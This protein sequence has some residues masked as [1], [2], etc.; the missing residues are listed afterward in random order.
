MTTLTDPVFSQRQVIT[1]E[2]MGA[3]A[4]VAADLDGDGDMDVVSASSTDNTVAWYERL[5]DGSFSGKKQITFSSNGARI[6]TTGDIDAD[7]FVDIV[8]ASYY[9][10]TVGW[11]KNSGTGTF[12]NLEGVEQTIIPIT[13]TADDAQGVI[14]A[15]IDGDGDL[16]VVSASSGDHTIAWYMNLGRDGLFCEVKNV[17]DS[18]AQ[19]ARTVVAADIDGDGDVDLASAAKDHNTIAWYPN[20]GHGNFPIKHVVYDQA[21]GAYS[22]VAKDVDR[23]GKVDLVTA[24]NA[25]DTIAFFRNLGSTPTSN[26]T[27]QRIEIFTGADFVLSVFAADLDGD[28]DIDAASAGF[29]DHTIRWHENLD[30]TGDSWTTHDIYTGQNSGGHYIFGEDM[31]N[32]G[33]TD[34]IAVMNGANEVMLL[35]ASTV[36]DTS[37]APTCCRLNQQWNG[38]SCVDCGPSLYGDPNPNLA[39][40]SCIACPTDCP[41]PASQPH[42]PVSC[43]NVPTCSTP[44]QAI[45]MCDCA[46]DTYKD[47]ETDVCV[48]CPEGFIRTPSRTRTMNDYFTSWEGFNA[49]NCVLYVP[50]IPDCGAGRFFNTSNEQ[51]VLC[52]DGTFSVGGAIVE[53]SECEA[54]FAC[55]AGENHPCQAG[56]FSGPGASICS[57]APR[58]THV[59]SVLA[60]EPT[61]CP[62]GFFANREGMQDC[63]QC[64]LGS[65]SGS[66]VGGISNSSNISVGAE[67]CIECPIS[68]TTARL[69]SRDVFDC[70]C[71]SGTFHE[72]HGASCNLSVDSPIEEGFC[73]PCPAGATCEGPVE[74]PTAMRSGSMDAGFVHQQPEVPA[75]FMAI[76]TD[77]YRC[78]GTGTACPGAFLFE[79]YDTMCSAGGHGVACAECDP[80]S[81]FDGEKCVECGDSGNIGMSAFLGVGLALAFALAKST[82]PKEPHA[83]PITMVTVNAYLHDMLFSACLS[84]SL[85]LVQTTWMFTTM[86]LSWPHTVAQT[87][88]AT[89]GIFDFT[90]FNMGCTDT[91]DQRRFAI[92]ST[93]SGLM[94]PGVVFGYLF[95]LAWAGRFAPDGAQWWPST[96]SALS[97]VLALFGTFFLMIANSAIGVGFTL[98][99]HPNGQYS[100]RKF[101]YILDTDPAFMVIR[102]ACAIG[103][104]VW[105]VMGMST[106]FWI[107]WKLQYKREDLQFRL[108]TMA[109]V[110]RYRPTTPWWYAFLLLVNLF[111]GL[112]GT[113]SEDGATQSLYLVLILM[114]YLVMLTS[115]RPYKADLC[116]Y[117]ELV[118][119]FGKLV[120]VVAGQRYNL[121]GQGEILLLCVAVFCYGYSLFTIAVAAYLRFRLTVWNLATDVCNFGRNLGGR[122]LLF[123]PQTGD[124]LELLKGA[125]HLA[126]YPHVDA[127]DGAVADLTLA[128][129]EL[130][131]ELQSQVD[132][133]IERNR[134]LEVQL[135]ETSTRIPAPQH[136]GAEAAPNKEQ[137]M[138]LPLQAA[139]LATSTGPEAESNKQQPS[140]LPK[141]GTS[142]SLE[143]CTSLEAASSAQDIEVTVVE[144]ALPTTQQASSLPPLED[145]TETW[146]NPVVQ[147]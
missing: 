23:D 130:C 29:F 75:G 55:T 47:A 59:P 35:T 18:N 121:T 26:V 5:A 96:A 112:A 126:S 98:I 97:Q 72:C 131:K 10:N 92:G 46:E 90:I 1:T 63:L 64:D 100:L 62:A 37:Q 122:A 66:L 48:S 78:G 40:P 128:S 132:D 33:D 120:L 81:S 58:G 116:H 83:S 108:S 125:H 101:P 138:L 113:I 84:I 79:D 25:D 13:V 145:A 9:D 7:G 38:T 137:A 124:L 16:D 20:D 107:L 123:L 4:A 2:A 54:G 68:L 76:G 141:R 134:S 87:F 22:L 144:E 135:L 104:L 69:G 32:D 15:D 3:R 65:Y 143:A 119:T 41:R 139:A 53:C 51:C 6:V 95:A 127:G 28:G 77:V 24:S 89:G 30:G 56:Y 115:V 50:T 27:F 67:S 118:A 71:K 111:L 129:K 11:F 105:C 44:E 114:S 8:V 88:S 39:A 103:V 34:L 85:T 142:T 140:L 21:M 117:L 57:A 147:T 61:P 12:T 31:D 19:G 52:P 102:I 146:Q 91:D 136:H 86:S 17:V 80:G 14:V 45:A 133:L 74:N 60:T 73:K 110:A 43:N 99:T 109:I 94:L 49:S 36:C 93:V 82:F 42:L 106:V 70:V